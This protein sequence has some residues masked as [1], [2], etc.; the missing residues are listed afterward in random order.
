MICAYSNPDD[1]CIESIFLI[2]VSCGGWVRLTAHIFFPSDPL[3]F[4][5]AIGFLDVMD[6]TVASLS[7]RNARCWE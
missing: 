5:L 2:F 7:G 1:L 4:S 3:C 6:R